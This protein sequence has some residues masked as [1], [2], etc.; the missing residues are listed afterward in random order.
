MQN[1]NV[2]KLP[3]EGM[4]CA[5][6]VRRVE[7]AL[8]AVPGVANAE[9]NLATETAAVTFAEGAS[10]EALVAA[11]RDAGYEA[12]LEPRPAPHADRSWWPLERAPLETPLHRQHQ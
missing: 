10:A 5:S 2:I 3:I 11:V 8:K 9:V 6:C 12:R 1:A 4:T 7:K